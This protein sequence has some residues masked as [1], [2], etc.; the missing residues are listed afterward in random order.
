MVLGLSD[1]QDPNAN[2]KMDMMATAIKHR[3]NKSM[4]ASQLNDKHTTH[5]RREKMQIE[6]AGPK[7]LNCLMLF[8]SSSLGSALGTDNKKKKG[9]DEETEI[10][11]RHTRKN[12]KIEETAFTS[13]RDTSS[14]CRPTKK[15]NKQGEKNTRTAN[16]QP[17]AIKRPASNGLQF[18]TINLLGNQERTHTHTSPTVEIMPRKHEDNFVRQT[19]SFSASSVFQQS[20]TGKTQPLGSLSLSLKRDDARFFWFRGRPRIVTAHLIA[21]PPPLLPWVSVQNFRLKKKGRGCEKHFRN[22]FPTGISLERVSQQN[23]RAL[24][25]V[26][27]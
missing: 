24:N 12:Q 23:I 22:C 19:F 18:P 5:K 9:A 10:S 21:P 11:R 16:T 2:N 17:T 15:Q 13:S 8:M 14:C 27:F 6:C 7:Q 3:I 20:K 1:F 25:V 4:R 26:V